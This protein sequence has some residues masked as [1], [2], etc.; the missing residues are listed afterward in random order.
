MCC[1]SVDSEGVHLWSS[2]TQGEIDSAAQPSVSR[3]F[4]LVGEL[5]SEEGVGLPM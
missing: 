2:E 4:T 3:Q 5:T 1:G